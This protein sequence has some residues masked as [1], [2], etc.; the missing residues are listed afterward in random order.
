MRT[1]V[2]PNWGAGGTR[3]RQNSLQMGTRL[4]ASIC[5]PSLPGSHWLWHWTE[6]RVWVF[7]AGPVACVIPERKW[8]FVSRS[9]CW[10]YTSQPET[11]DCIGSP[12]RQVEPADQ[13]GDTQA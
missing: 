3:P 1:G 6:L 9:G 2:F 7:G 4:T 5:Q 11:D 12:A 13:V 10:L 8:V